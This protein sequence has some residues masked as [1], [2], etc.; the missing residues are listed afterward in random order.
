MARNGWKRLGTTTQGLDLDVNGDTRVTFGDNTATITSDG[1]TPNAILFGR[2]T[3]TTRV[4]TSSAGKFA[5]FYTESTATS[6]SVE[7]LYFR[8]YISG[9]GADGHALRAY[10]TVNNVTATTARGG[11]VSLSFG[12]SGLISGLGA[13]LEATLHIPNTA[14]QS[15]T[16]TALNAAINSDGATS[17]PAGATSLS[18][19]RCVSQGDA[20]G[21]A[22]VDTDAVFVDFSGLTAGSGKMIYDNTGTDPTN[23]NGS[24]KI[25]LPSGALAYLMYY[26]QQAA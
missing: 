18:F 20:T 19:I 14:T 17:D 6:G 25:R 23:S 12:D 4:A 5:S 15:G 8:T 1:A 26:D 16:L 21:M 2:G 10:T 3:S 24:I 13:A 22:D 7:G 9:A 11:H